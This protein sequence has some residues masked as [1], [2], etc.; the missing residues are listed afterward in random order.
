MTIKSVSTIAGAILAVGIAFGAAG[1]ANAAPG[2]GSLNPSEIVA[3]SDV[4][5]VS[6]RYRRGSRYRRG[7]SRYWGGR[8]Y[9]RCLPTYRWVRYY[10][11]WVRRFG[12][13][14]C[15]SSYRPYYGY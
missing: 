2:V 10:G 3:N 4:T 13:Y 14:P 7:G 15:R 12:G 8:G 9:R 5:T 1:A 11:T 6:H